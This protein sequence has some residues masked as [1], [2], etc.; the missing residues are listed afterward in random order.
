MGRLPSYFYEVHSLMRFFFFL[1]FVWYAFYW[2]WRLEWEYRTGFFFS[3][4]LLIWRRRWNYDGVKY[5]LFWTISN[6]IFSCC[7]MKSRV[8]C[9]FYISIS[10]A[11]L[12][13]TLTVLFN[14]LFEST[15]FLKKSTFKREQK[16][17]WLYFEF[18]NKK[19]GGGKEKYLH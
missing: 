12:S 6:F 11:I 8:E 17:R 7:D 15:G 13:S 16:T 2:L 9:R 10:K 14:S 18:C 19:S 4:L 3:F 5:N 1:S